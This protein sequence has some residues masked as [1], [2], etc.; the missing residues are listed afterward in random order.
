MTRVSV[1][2]PVYN[3]GPFLRGAIASILAQT[4]ADL[5]LLIIDDGSTDASLETIAQMAASDRR[6]RF[7]SRANKGLVH[8]L[9]ELLA[10]AQSPFIARMDADDLALPDRFDRR[11]PGIRERRATAGCRLRRVLDRFQGPPAHD[12]RHAALSPGNRGLYPFGRARLRNVPPIHDVQRASV[13]VGWP[14]PGG[15][16][17]GGRRRPPPANRRARQGREH[18]SPAALLPG[19]RRQHWPSASRAPARRPVP[20][21]FGQRPIDAGLRPC[22]I[23]FANCPEIRKIASK[24]RSRATSSGLGG[25]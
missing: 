3:G 6:I 10:R 11:A 16:L 7:W 23:H 18:R 22:R 14:L 24:P 9:N 21:R 25:R 15:S 12:D 4:M 17:A 1:L 2:L 19:A 5:E 8:T 13:R 20:G